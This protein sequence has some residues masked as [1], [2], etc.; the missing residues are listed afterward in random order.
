MTG[1]EKRMA[2]AEAAARRGLETLVS[3]VPPETRT[4][5]TTA[6]AALDRFMS[7]NAE[8]IVLSRRNSNV[9]SLALSLGQKRTLTAKCEETLHALQDALGKR[10][11]GGTR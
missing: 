2:T 5:L 6:T 4:R 7:V 10:G 9:R 11:F 3:V 8:I 1:M